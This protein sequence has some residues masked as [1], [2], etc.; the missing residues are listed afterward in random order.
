MRTVIGRE[1]KALAGNHGCKSFRV[2]AEAGKALRQRAF[3]A[4]P[5]HGGAA[6]KGA[7]GYRDI[8]AHRRKS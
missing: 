6:K 5:E 4:E 8:I 2:L 3:G 1:S 7:A